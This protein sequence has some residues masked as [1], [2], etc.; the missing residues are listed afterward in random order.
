MSTA[1]P[2]P[3]RRFSVDDVER[4]VE[5]GILGED[6]RV[7][8]IE[9]ELIV[10]AP[11]APEHADITTRLH[12]RLR[13]AFG[14]G[15]VVREAKPLVIATD[16]L[17]EPDLAVV[18]GSYA[19]FARR[20]PRGDEAVLVVEVAVSSLLVDRAKA[21]TYARA[22]VPRYWLLDVGTGR[23]E[24]HEEPHADGR[25]GLVRVLAGG[26]VLELRPGVGV[27]VHALL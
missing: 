23:V 22:G 18:A 4:M 13:Q 21:A 5:A 10:M 2:R 6:E 9:G 3:V 26:D 1:T 24:A 17:P 8:L 16:G 14:A 12:D 27:A 7:E 11:Q 20:H 15:F 25:Y 19:D